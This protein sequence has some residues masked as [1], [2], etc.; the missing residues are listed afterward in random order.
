MNNNNKNIITKKASGI[1][2][3]LEK[4]SFIEKEEKY[5]E[6]YLGKSGAKNVALSSIRKSFITMKENNE[7]IFS[8]RAFLDAVY[9]LAM[10]RQ[11]FTP[12]NFKTAFEYLENNEHVTLKLRARYEKQAR[13]L[14]LKDIKE[15]K[16][17]FLLIF[18]SENYKDIPS[19]EAE[20][21][22]ERELSLEKLE[23]ELDRSYALSVKRAEDK[24]KETEITKKAKENKKKIKE[25]NLSK[26]EEDA[27]LY[28]IKQNGG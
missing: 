14:Y 5:L 7:K 4:R 2:K 21:F 22:L 24:N 8:D 15:E 18:L 9:F 27:L 19:E 25:N 12:S 11:P 28:Y 17:D 26:E 6:K 13:N 1:I 20:I 23:M 3:T 10:E 16:K